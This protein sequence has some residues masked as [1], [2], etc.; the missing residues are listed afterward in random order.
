MRNGAKEAVT[1][2]TVFKN[3]SKSLYVGFDVT[4]N[5]HNENGITVTYCKGN[6]QCYTA[7]VTTHDATRFQQQA[8]CVSTLIWQIV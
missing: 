4:E 7:S 1:T 8:I 2:N 3:N 6:V 5:T